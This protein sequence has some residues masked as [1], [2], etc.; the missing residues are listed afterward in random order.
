MEQFVTQK[1]TPSLWFDDNAEDATAFYVSIF[2]NGKVLDISRYGEAGPGEQ[3]TV[4]TTRFTIAGLEFM[5][6]NGGPE[7]SINPSISFLVACENEQQVDAL[8]ERLT[9][10]GSVLMEL[11]VYPFS[12]KYGWVQDAYGVSWQVSLAGTPQSITPSLMFVGARHGQ[13]EEAIALYTSLFEGA[14]IDHIQKYGAGADEPEGTV[15]FAAFT[16]AGQAFSAMDSNQAHE[17]TFNEGISLSVDCASQEEVDHFWDKLIEGGG[18]P[19]QC[20]WL[21][22]RFGV[23]WQIVP[24]ALGT[25]LGDPDPGKANRVMQAMLQMT[26]IEVAGLQEAYDAA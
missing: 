17:F 2:S 25:L 19:S 9:D 14:S 13:A 22:D 12:E 24:S 20:G 5:T 18:E 16:L 4:L 23:S 26:K 7:F 11:G 8:W 1:I 6:I 3:G 10:G 21:K 15:Q